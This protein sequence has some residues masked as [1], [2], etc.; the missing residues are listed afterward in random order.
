M[1]DK[2]PIIHL[3]KPKEFRV[4][5]RPSKLPSTEM[6]TT[7]FPSKASCVNCLSALRYE[8]QRANGGKH[9]RGD[10][11]F[12]KKWTIRTIRNPDVEELRYAKDN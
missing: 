9:V 4:W 6:I 7:M 2:E 8:R 11:E 5:C 1:S 3:L 12:R 10:G